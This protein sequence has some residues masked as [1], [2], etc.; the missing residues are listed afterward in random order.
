MIAASPRGVPLA[1][2]P[3]DARPPALVLGNEESGLSPAVARECDA[4]VAIA[5]SGRVESLNVSVAAGI[6]IHALLARA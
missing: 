1:T 4:A 3:A 6:L 2:L 5:G